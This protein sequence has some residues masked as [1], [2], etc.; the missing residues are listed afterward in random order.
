MKHISL[1]KIIIALCICNVYVFTCGVMG[2]VGDGK[3]AVDNSVL[4]ADGSG[5]GITDGSSEP[6]GTGE[7]PPNGMGTV[8]F[9]VPDTAQTETMHLKELRFASPGLAESPVQSSYTP[10]ESTPPIDTFEAISPVEESREATNEIHI[11]DTYEPEDEPPATTATT[12]AT[13]TTP[14]TTATSAATTATTPQ[15]TPS[16]TPETTPETTPTTPATPATPASTPSTFPTG[17]IPVNDDKPIPVD[18]GDDIPDYTEPTEIIP[19][20]DAAKEI[21]YVTNRGMTVSGSAVD[22]VSRVTQNEMGYTFAPEAI[23]AQ[24][25]AAYTYIKYCNEYGTYPS[26]LLS[27]TVNDSVRVLTESV[28]G[29]AI[30]YDGDYIQ[31]VYSASSAGYTASSENVWGN[32]YPYLTSVFCELDAK[33]DPN[34][35][36]TVTYSSEEIKN[37]IQNVTGISLSGD[38]SGW[39]SIDGYSDGKYV[40]QMNIGG[41]HSYTGSSGRTVKLSGRAFRENIM[42]YELRS[43]AFDVSYD[44]STDMFTFTTYGYGHGVGMSQNGAN[45][46]A[47]QWGYD[48]KQILEFYYTGA[49]VK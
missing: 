40:E 5:N 31:A 32:A 1:I 47:S 8:D 7:A 19:N 3:S 37:R 46:L 11:V 22:I 43:A 13:S 15:T 4:G 36:R 38:P 29:Q 17:G 18:S 26:V 27:E 21:L 41:Y 42:D 14:T 33:Y 48:Y 16:T 44:S 24:A 25:V 9:I 39:I 6:S 10:E 34:Y 12:P 2:V 20:A 30:Y 28:I 45:N 35:G 49:T 23:K